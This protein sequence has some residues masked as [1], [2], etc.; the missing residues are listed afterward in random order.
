MAPPGT[1]PQ[2]VPEESDPGA[3]PLVD[4]PKLGW[5]TNVG[6]RL[7]RPTGSGGATR[8]SSDISPANIRIKSNGGWILLLVFVVLGVGAA[9][10]AYFLY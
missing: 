3:R 6:N 2:L 5:S 4:D 10:A 1:L 7:H 8:L 9:V